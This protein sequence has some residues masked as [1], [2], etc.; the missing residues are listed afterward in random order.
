MAI[1]VITFLV[2]L[3]VIFTGLVLALRPSREQKAIHRR[4]TGIK[5]APGE[6][7]GDKDE[8]SKYL[9]A[10]D[11]GTFGWIEA[12]LADSS[13]S[14]S[15]KLMLLQADSTTS[16]GM[17]IVT[18]LGAGAAGA[19]V[20]FIASGM[21]L[22]AAPAGLIASYIPVFLLK[23]RGKRRLNAFNRALPDAIDMMSRCLR[24]GHSMS[25][26]IG[27]IAE[28]SAEPVKTEF[29]EIFKKQNFGL[30]MR[31][32]LMQLLD[33]IPSQDLRV[34]VT[35]I[36]V[37]KD[38]G[39]NLVDILDRI[40]HVIRE[41]I[42]IKGEIQTHTAQGRLT[43]W[44]LCM[45][46]VAMLGLINIINP[47]YSKVLFTEPVGQKLLGGG[48]FLLCVGGLIIRGIINGIEV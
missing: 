2:T 16:V 44:I 13:V 5:A 17:T 42:R 22:V 30:P 15:I 41:R 19:A 27:I 21:P 45:L 8:I 39:G 7:G 36:L 40:V 1:L 3:V 47:G 31:D 20:G 35:G 34:L 37:Q 38:T 6:L 32:A 25:S 33:R 26:A 43:G 12:W 24:A 18:V 46:P 28:Q 4:I 14:E 48:I 11:A 29:A 10:Q 23:F 9:T